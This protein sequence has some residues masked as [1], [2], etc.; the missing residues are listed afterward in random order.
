MTRA[1]LI[2]AAAAACV[3]VSDAGVR[4]QKPADGKEVKLTGTM[5][6]GSCALKEAKKCTN[7]LQVKEGDKTV[8]Y[9]LDDKG[10]GEPYHDKVCGGDKVEG[11]TVTGTVSEKDGKKWVKATKVDLKK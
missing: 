1:M 7:V 5:V 6:C 9:Y 2:A 8:N 10:A 4:A 3:W 11:V